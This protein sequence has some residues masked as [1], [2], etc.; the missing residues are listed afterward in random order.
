MSQSPRRELRLQR[1]LDG[2]EII[3]RMIREDT[4]W[5]G[6]ERNCLHLST[7][8]GSFIDISAA[9]GLD[10]L[11]DGRAL[12][13]L[14]YDLD[15]RPDLALRNRDGPQLRILRNTWPGSGQALWIRLEGRNCNR[16]AIGARISLSGNG[17]S[18]IKEVR[19]GAAFLSQSSRWS[20]FAIT[21]PEKLPTV[22]VRWPGGETVEYGQLDPGGRWVIVEGDSPTRLPFRP[23]AQQLPAKREKEQEPPAPE[24]EKAA[25]ETWLVSP[26]PAPEL[27]WTDLNGRQRSPGEFRGKPVLLQLFSRDCTVCVAGLEGMLKA[28]EEIHNRGG[29]HLVAS[30]DLGPIPS[31]RRNFLSRVE[32]PSIAL[33]FSERTLAGW[34][35]LFRHLFNHRRDLV[36]P[37]SFLIDELG[38]IVKVYRGKTDPAKIL[39]DLVRIPRTDADRTG[40]ALPFKGTYLFPGFRRDLLELGNAYSDAGL[41]R[42][43]RTVFKTALDG[44]KD[45]ADSLFNYAISSARSGEVEEARRIYLEI[46]QENPGYDDARNNLGILDARAGRLDTARKYFSAV[47]QNNPAHTEAALNLAN[48]WV[49]AGEFE[50]AAE[51]YRQALQHDTGSAALNRMLGLALFRSGEV[52]ESILAHEEAIRLDPLDLDAHRNLAIILISSGDHRRAAAISEAGLS[53]GLKSGLEN[54]PV[55]A[56]L[57]NT[58]GMALWKL[59]EK[60]RAEGELKKAIAADPGFDRPYLNLSRLLVEQGRAREATA[61]LGALLQLVPGHQQAA[62]MLQQ[63]ESSKP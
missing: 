32:A 42:L 29:S 56:G 18:R 43:A 11:Q 12:A 57:L 16:D 2:W 50:T 27:P 45:N 13:R 55:Q 19:A 53:A 54:S 14:D 35:I 3:N 62:E 47:L 28:G 33:R 23:P 52:E 6:R 15:G 44:Q 20:C 21:D 8:K 4:S 22:S 37:T 17:S 58:H 5:G 10:Y 51:V 24:A 25:L 38:N 1:Y 31:G 61:V 30:V 7:G 63:L 34:N 39:D 40:K 60:T 26:M 9:S 59:G 36:V 48:T 49:Q 46:L 41:P